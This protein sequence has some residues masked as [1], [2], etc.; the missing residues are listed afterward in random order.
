MSENERIVMGL[1]QQ[2]AVLGLA[3]VFAPIGVI[4]AS[5]ARADCVNAGA[6]TVCAQGTVTGGG[7]DAPTAGPYMP[8]PCEYDWLCDDGGLSIV[9]NPPDRPVR[10]GG[11]GGPR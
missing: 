4:E 7:P 5:P 10:P 2:C 11:G 6:A 1:W 9:I 8:Y 3:A